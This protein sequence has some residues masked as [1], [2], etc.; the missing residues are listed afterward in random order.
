M[1]PID[2]STYFIPFERATNYRKIHQRNSIPIVSVQCPFIVLSFVCVVFESMNI[3]WIW[4]VHMHNAICYASYCCVRLSLRW[5]GHHWGAGHKRVKGIDK[6]FA[7]STIESMWTFWLCIVS[8]HVEDLDFLH[9]SI[10]IRRNFILYSKRWYSFIG[11]YVSPLACHGTTTRWK[12]LIQY[13]APCTLYASV[14]Y[15]HSR[16]FAVFF[17]LSPFLLSPSRQWL[18]VVLMFIYKCA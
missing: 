9:L 15:M 11:I 13:I 6:T 17:E 10:A 7:T 1:R 2:W 5:C 3:P 14:R 16:H 12:I 4:T 18:M 8:I